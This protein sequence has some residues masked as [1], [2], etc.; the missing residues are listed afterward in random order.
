M[1]RELS[2]RWIPAGL[3]TLYALAVLTAQP[4][5]AQDGVDPLAALYPGQQDAAEGL[6]GGTWPQLIETQNRGFLVFR[7]RVVANGFAIPDTGYV[8]PDGRKVYVAIQES[9]AP[10]LARFTE[11]E[12]S[13]GKAREWMMPEGAMPLN[14]AA[15]GNRFYAILHSPESEVEFT[16]ARVM[17]S[18]NPRPLTSFNGEA[19]QEIDAFGNGLVVLSST[20]AAARVSPAAPPVPSQAPP[21]PPVF[22]TWLFDANDRLSVRHTFAGFSDAVWMSDR[23]RLLLVKRGA[24]LPG[25]RRPTFTYVLAD[26]STGRTQPVTQEEIMQSPQAPPWR[27]MLSLQRVEVEAARVTVGWL[28]DSERLQASRRVAIQSGGTPQAPPPP[29]ELGD[30]PL[31][32]AVEFIEPVAE[33]Q[34]GLV[35]QADRAVWYVPIVEVPAGQIDRLGGDLESR[36]L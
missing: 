33:R 6:Q 18:A 22:S 10:L 15:V 23:S 34:N 21:A 30:T 11:F 4:V 8:S 29:S 1:R 25:E 3:A 28:T 9:E 7:P 20:G 35:I 2:L 14:L 19:I 36:R 32:S 5:A 16:V 13:T 31:L 17:G 24:P 12:V 27:F 26:P